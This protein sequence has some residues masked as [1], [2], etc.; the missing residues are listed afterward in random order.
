MFVYSKH[1][2][3][4]KVQ[5]SNCRTCW[6]WNGAVFEWWSEN[7]TKFV[8]FVVENVWYLNGLPDHVIRPFENR[9]KKCLK[10]L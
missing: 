9:T 8:C 5:Y 7:Q 4:T 2:N 10:I 6:L 3:T 1:L